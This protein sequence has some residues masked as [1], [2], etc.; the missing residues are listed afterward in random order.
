MIDE[1]T[2]CRICD[3]TELIP[4]VD[5]GEQY[6]TGIF[7]KNNATESLIKGPLRLMKC[8]GGKECCGLL[9]LAH[10]YDVNELYG[11]NYGYRSGL[12][13][14]MVRHLHSKMAD[15]IER[16]DLNKGDLV[17]DIGSNDGTTLAAYPDH[18]QLVG[19]D[20]T[21]EK[22]RSY[23]EKHI[24]LI[25]EFFSS[26]LISR[27]FPEK[28]VKVVTSLSMFYDLEDPVDFACQVASI[29][30]PREGIWV[31][32]QSYMP[33]MLE[34]TAY[35]TICH[36]HLEYY[37]LRQIVWLMDKAGLE[38]VNVE[39]NDVN[40]GSFSVIVAHKGSKHN[41]VNN[42]VD[43]LIAS[44]DKKGLSSIEPYKQFAR[45]AEENKQSL[46]DFVQQAKQEG[47]RIC[48]IGS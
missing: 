13:A 5:L 32:E 46:Q 47:K 14:S 4:V 25:P 27:S 35:D 28:K 18:F 31:L 15:I 30:D 44:E 36:E 39:L 1:I 22:F 20:P 38:V 24:A 48:G 45:R 19:I 11:D 34:R 8:H 40:G 10:S 43:R 41:D 16:C 9:Q 7:P 6:L 21:G 17:I 29:L 33:L 23:Y 2:K 12:N 37:G 3:N 42:I 26:D